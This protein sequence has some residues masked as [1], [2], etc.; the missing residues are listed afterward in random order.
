MTRGSYN[1]TD[2]IT[3]IWQAS[4]G[5]LSME[6]AWRPIPEQAFHLFIYLFRAVSHGRRIFF[7]KQRQSRYPS[8]HQ[9]P[10][11]CQVAWAG[12]CY[13]S[14]CVSRRT[15][16]AAVALLTLHEDAPMQLRL[17]SSAPKGVPLLPQG[18][19]GDA[20]HGSMHRFMPGVR[21][22]C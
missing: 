16:S 13:C 12:C 5:A 21:K 19:C 1:G 14:L 20:M 2:R 17:L 10:G 15:S 9:E 22:R 6:T 4:R 7:A 11:C 8:C 18:D 3:E